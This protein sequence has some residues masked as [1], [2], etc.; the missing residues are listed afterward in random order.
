M[1]WHADTALPA[2]TEL[3]VLPGGF[4]YGDYLRCGAIAARAPIMAAVR[5]HA[6]QRRARARRLQR[7][8]DP[9]RGGA[10]ARRSDAQC[11][12]QVHLPRCLS[13]RRALRYAVHPRLQCRP[14]DAR[15]GRARRGQL[16][17]RRGTISRGSRRGQGAVSLRRAR[18]HV[19]IPP[20]TSMAPRNAIAG[21]LNEQR[22]RARHDAASREPRGSR[23][24]VRPTAADCS[25]GSPIISRARPEPC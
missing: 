16:R 10:A 7:L 23:R 5:A 6:D 13:A 22:Q 24:S 2:G 20:G 1:V 12:A 19:S 21:V 11:G 14:G 8:P 9:V 25:Q 3:V 15:A 17:R 4:S 18:R